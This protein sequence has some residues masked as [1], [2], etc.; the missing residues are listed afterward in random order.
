MSI[1]FAL[2]E[3]EIRLLK[4]DSGREGEAMISCQMIAVPL[5]TGHPAYKALSYTWG[6]EDTAMEISING[7]SFSIR[8]NLYRVLQKMIKPPWLG[9][10]A[11]PGELWWID[12]I[13]IDQDNHLEKEQQVAMMGDVYRFSDLTVGWLGEAEYG[14]HLAVSYLS[15]LGEFE[16]TQMQEAKA[17]LL[18]GDFAKCLRALKWLFRRSWWVRAWTLQ[19]YVIPE[20][21]VFVCGDSTIGRRR[22]ERAISWLTSLAS[23]VQE[24]IQF[25]KLEGYEIA[26]KRRKL[27]DRRYDSLELPLCDALIYAGGSAA[28]KG[29]DCVYSLLGLVTDHVILEIEP[30]YDVDIDDATIFEKIIRSQINHAQCIDIICFSNTTP[31]SLGCPTWVPYW[32]SHS[33]KANDRMAWQSFPSLANISVRAKPDGGK[34]EKASFRAAGGF[35]YQAISG[36][37][38]PGVLVCEGVLL[39]IIEEL[40]RSSSTMKSKRR[41]S[42]SATQSQPVDESEQRPSHSGTSPRSRHVYKIPEAMWRTLVLDREDGY[43]DSHPPLEYRI[44]FE[45]LCRQAVDDPLALN[46]DVLCWFQSNASIIFKSH[47]EKDLIQNR[48]SSLLSGGH[49]RQRGNIMGFTRQMLNV[50]M[51]MKKVLCVLDNG[52]LGM[53]PRRAR[54]GDQV[55]ILAG[56]NFPVTL[57]QA[58]QDGYFYMIGECYVSNSMQGEAV[59]QSSGEPVL[60]KTLRLL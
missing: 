2:S 34:G 35:P 7:L 14:S 28:S 53:A 10:Q 50:W 32:P 3:G 47:P 6:G 41:Q 36:K 30:Q 22:F 37:Q 58:D 46:S 9:G 57:R 33:S 20:N 56:C 24:H 18:D 4:V 39:G 49:Y 54:V 31:G 59:S 55:W 60:W 19:E 11:T 42:S 45:W 51:N 13:C 1:Y 48:L 25:S 38:E 12:A 40:G 27:R 21:F 15:G 44:E 17:F 26:W 43:L 52:K 8:L 16:S 5:R 23:Y 29:R